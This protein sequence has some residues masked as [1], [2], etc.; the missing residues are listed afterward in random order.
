MSFGS[1]P[2]D[3]LQNGLD[4]DKEALK[5]LKSAALGLPLPG[6]TAAGRVGRTTS[7]AGVSFGPPRPTASASGLDCRGIGMMIDGSALGPFPILTLV[8]SARNL[9]LG[10]TQRRDGSKMG[11]A[12][13]VL[14]LLLLGVIAGCIRLT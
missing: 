8:P 12:S 7:E 1:P 9:N 14:S 4:P 13:V 6:P 2:C 5:A 10:R 11:S 3:V